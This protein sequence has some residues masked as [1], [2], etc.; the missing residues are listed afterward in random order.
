MQAEVFIEKRVDVGN[1]DFKGDTCA[2]MYCAFS[3]NDRVESKHRIKKNLRRPA[4]E[5]GDVQNRKGNEYAVK[6][7]CVEIV[8]SFLWNSV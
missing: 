5:G 8:L 4:G 1:N 7:A 2:V 6:L 3:A